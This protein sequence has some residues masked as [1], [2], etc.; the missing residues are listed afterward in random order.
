MMKP[1]VGI[2]M[3]DPAGIGPEITV[4]ALSHP[5]VYDISRP[6]VIGDADY[7]QETVEWLGL[8]G[9]VE[10]V[11]VE[12][13]RTEDLGS[14][15]YIPGKIAVYDVDSG[16]GS[17]GFQP[18]TPQSGH[19]ALIWI[20]AAAR[21]ALAGTIDA[22]CTAPINK[23]AIVKAG[24]AGFKGHTEFLGELTGT[25]EPLTMFVVDNL[26]IFFLTRHVSLRK[27]VE[28]VTLKRLVEFVPRCNEALVALGL[29]APRIAIAGLNPHCGEG[30]LFG[31]EEEK[32]IA[33]AVS[34]LRSAGYD[35]TGPVPAD[36][37]FY[38]ARTGKYDA[39][40]SLY[41][42]QGHIAAKTLDFDR[43][44]SVTLGLPFLRTSV[45]HGT[46]Y[47]IAGKGIARET[48]MLEAL[49]VA[50]LYARFYAPNR[51]CG[52]DDSCKIE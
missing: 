4:K 22:I 5:E 14:F 50:S 31:D 25:P 3:G 38:Q 21:L 16:R 6:L 46:A 32:E 35:V 28:A 17:S 9:S 10:V 37:V 11:R 40:V 2:T 41:H 45:D 1:V 52:K 15:N 43:T 44:V 48:S 19:A 27:A 42:D 47:D 18:G 51:L 12:T 29:K 13:E 33:P 8:G 36:S 39:V 23:E 24:Y 49:K 26:R 34:E 30:G 20:E 7:L